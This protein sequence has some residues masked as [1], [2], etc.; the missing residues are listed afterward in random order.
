MATNTKRA[1]PGAKPTGRAK[2]AVTFKLSPDVLAFLRAQT[3]S[4]QAVMIERAVRQ[5][6]AYNDWRGGANFV[7]AGGAATLPPEGD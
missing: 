2:K 4:S 5:T 3:E 1:K 6:I 7:V